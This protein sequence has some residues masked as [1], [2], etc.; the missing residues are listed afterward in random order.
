MQIHYEVMTF[1]T[2][3]GRLPN[4]YF[5]H[6]PT[7]DGEKIV[8]SGFYL[9]PLAVPLTVKNKFDFSDAETVELAIITG[10]IEGPALI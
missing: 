9:P 10:T 3:H 2:K 5:V 6:R 8:L 1:A 7:K 4:V